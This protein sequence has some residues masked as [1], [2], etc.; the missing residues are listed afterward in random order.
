M[1]VTPD[2]QSLVIDGVTYQWRIEDDPRAGMHDFSH[3]G[4]DQETVVIAGDD[5][6]TLRFFL[7]DHDLR[8]RSWWRG[9]RRLTPEVVERAI[10]IARRSSKRQLEY[11]EV[12][13]A[14]DGPTRTLRE[15]LEAASVACEALTHGG[16]T[17]GHVFVDVVLEIGCFGNVDKAA[18][19][20]WIALHAQ[21]LFGASRALRQLLDEDGDNERVYRNRSALAFLIEMC[22]RNQIGLAL[23]TSAADAR[24]RKRTA[25]AVKPWGIPLSHWW[26][27]QGASQDANANDYQN[28]D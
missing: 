27:R 22:E 10:H 3:R 14:F 11:S 6:T 7:P 9:P 1:Q 24:L 15:N 17:A 4:A 26:W 2:R 5:G 18:T 28:D 23:D 20:D 12:I 21:E 16:L 8:F 25:E 19:D 13:E